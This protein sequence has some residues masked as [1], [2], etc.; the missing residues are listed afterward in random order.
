MNRCNILF[1]ISRVEECLEL[2]FKYVDYQ[3]LVQLSYSSCSCL[4]SVR[5]TR[6]Q[7]FFSVG[8]LINASI[9]Q[10]VFVMHKHNAVT[11]KAVTT[12]V[13]GQMTSC[14]LYITWITHGQMKRMAALSH[15]FHDPVV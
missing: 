14:G 6:T 10:L 15:S 11:L 4:T 7:C 13:N 8:V 1:A 5:P 12:G 2:N 9:V 3:T